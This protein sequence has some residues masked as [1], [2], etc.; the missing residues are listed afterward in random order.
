MPEPKFL[1][2]ENLGAFL[3][4]LD[5]SRKYGNVLAGE[6]TL[7]KPIEDVPA[8]QIAA[9]L[10]AQRPVNSFKGV[11]MPARELVA[12]Y[13]EA[14]GEDPLDVAA[15]QTIALVGVRGC[16]L[17]A[18]A[19]LDSVMLEEPQEPFYRARREQMTIIAV[20][21]TAPCP[22]CFC[23]LLGG[24]PHPEK[25]FD[26]N[27]SPV[28]GGYV[29]EAGSEKGTELLEKCRGLLIDAAENH[30]AQKEAMRQKAAEQLEQQNAE[31]SIPE[32]IKESLP[33]SIDGRFW[34]RELSLCVQCGGCTAVCP[35]CYC[36]LLYDKRADGKAYE[37]AR[38]WDS[39]Q[40]TGYSVMAGPPGTRK[41]DPRRNHMSKF[42]HRFAHKFW[43]DPINWGVFGCVGCGRCSQT[44]PGAIDPRRVLS[45]VKKE[46]V[47]HG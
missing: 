10:R 32:D 15:R 36:F 44:C 25:L 6:T 47:E 37:R 5:V 34:R 2:E 39:C 31:Y 46:L 23:N 45:E 17:R 40:F 11:L 42:Q 7:W 28:E 21:C 8:E 16:E 4:E 14:E 35:T 3:G 41:P 19:Y 9:G 22:T 43:Y 30:L 13:G 24:R 27:L 29:A 12:R 1:T 18:L 20:D 26:V 38:V 33:Q